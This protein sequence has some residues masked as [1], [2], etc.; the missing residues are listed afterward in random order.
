V[1]LVVDA[2]VVVAA[3]IDSGPEGAWAAQLLGSDDLAAPHLMPAE[4]A[5]V[6]RLAALAGDVSRESATL[7]YTDLLALPVELFPYQP[8][9]LRVWELRETVT[10]YDA[11]YVALAEELGLTL[12]TL[13]ARLARVAGPRCRFQTFAG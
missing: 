4:A 9:A 3:L 6:L 5:N 12:A 10:A 1:T 11:W 7:G 2:S 8:F 13:D